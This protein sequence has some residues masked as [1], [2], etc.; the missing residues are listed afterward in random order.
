MSEGDTCSDNK[1][2]REI[3]QVPIQDN[4]S[5]YIYRKRN[6]LHKI[7]YHLTRLGYTNFINSLAVKYILLFL[8]LQY[9]KS[10]EHKNQ[11]LSLVKEEQ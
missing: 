5:K 4:I 7:S 9:S 1:M 10:M 8:T 2:L 11:K 6:R 3:N